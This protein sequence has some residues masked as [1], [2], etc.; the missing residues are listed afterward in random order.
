MW[1]PIYNP[2]N[3]HDGGKLSPSYPR[4]GST[5]TEMSIPSPSGPIQ[6]AAAVYF[7]QQ[8]DDW[9]VSHI[10]GSEQV[11]DDPQVMKNIMDATG[12]KPTKVG[13]A[14]GGLVKRLCRG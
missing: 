2:V 6:D 9:K 12:I 10:E 4:A 3:K 8:I 5:R 7:T 13:I 14:P 1:Y 11:L